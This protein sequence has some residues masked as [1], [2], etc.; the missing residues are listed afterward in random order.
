MLPNLQKALEVVA[1]IS[2]KQTLV[3]NGVAKSGTTW[4]QRILNAHPE[5]FCPGEGKFSHLLRGLSGA[6]KDYNKALDYT[7]RVIYGQQNFYNVWRIEEAA[8]AFQFCIALSWAVSN[9][10]RLDTVKYIGDKDTEYLSNIE[11]WRDRLLPDARFIHVIRDG[12]DC[13][14]SNL[15]QKRRVGQE[16]EMT[17]ESF[18][19]FVDSYAK[20]WSAKVVK[21]RKAFANLPERYHEVRY[22]DLSNAPTRTIK[23]LFGFLGVADDDALIEEISAASTF[24]K[25]SGGRERGKESKESFYRKGVAGDWHNHFDEK[26]RRI[27]TTNAGETLVSLGYS[28]V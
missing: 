22:E 4:V 12:R 3:V 16:V 19:G 1:D 24:E 23:G 26:A 7:N 11:L 25:F 6:V 18:Y 17:G 2:N 14:V 28:D 27:F 15:L 9:H 5:V 20:G 10:G 8:T 13:A 21:F